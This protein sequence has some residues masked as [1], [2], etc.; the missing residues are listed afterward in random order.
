[1]QCNIYVM[2]TLTCQL[3]QIV[4][5]PMEWS[6]KPSQIDRSFGS[7]AD[8]LAA[9][10]VRLEPRKI[11]EHPFHGTIT[12]TEAAPVRV[13]RVIAT[14]HRILRL[15]SHIAQSKEDLCFINLQLAGVGR[16]TQ[17]KHEQINGPADIAVVDTTEPFELINA[18]DFK[19]FCIAVPRHLLPAAFWER[20]RLT[21]SAT[22]GGR[23]LSRTL[24]G[25]AELSISSR[26]TSEVSTLVGRHIVDLISHAPEILAEGASER[27]DTPVLLMM[28]IDHID[29]HSAEPDLSAA[30][31]ARKFHCSERYVHKLFAATGRSVGEH[32]NDRRIAA[33]TRDLLDNPRNRTV[34]EIA[35][36]AGFRDVSYFNRLFKRT[37]GTAPREFRRAMNRT[38][39]DLERS[40]GPAM[41]S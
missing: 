24:A 21:L 4:A 17:R 25:Y 23:A 1:M 19:V 38:S 16:Y 31:L 35:F 30:T 15:R 36:G 32:V 34:A 14:R 10:F 37:N 40:S 20:P 7:W 28:M 9:A 11:T 41:R 29:H 33:C 18:H 3:H 8:D 22:E 26:S 2:E 5:A 13:S 27:I 39:A 12:R 6:A